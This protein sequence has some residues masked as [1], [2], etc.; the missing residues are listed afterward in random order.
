MGDFLSGILAVQ[1]KLRA[2]ITTVE[3]DN[4]MIVAEAFLPEDRLDPIIQIVDKGGSLAHFDAADEFQDQFD[5]VCYNS[6][7]LDRD[8]EEGIIDSTEGVLQMALDVYTA[9]RRFT[10]AAVQYYFVMIAHSGTSRQGSP[11]ALFMVQK[12]LTFE[13]KNSG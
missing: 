10:D 2:D 6:I 9:L 5:I 3:D 7:E 8:F 12:T 11:E 4:I 13:N 1:V